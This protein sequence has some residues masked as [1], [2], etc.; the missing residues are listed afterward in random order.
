MPSIILII[1]SYYYC[2]SSVCLQSRHLFVEGRASMCESFLPCCVSIEVMMQSLKGLERQLWGTQSAPN[3]FK[4]TYRS[5]LTFE[6]KKQSITHLFKTFSGLR[7]GCNAFIL[8]K[9]SE[10]TVNVVFTLAFTTA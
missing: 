3:R 7:L 10:N 5:V 4:T 2:A 6:E 1:A 8:S 9:R